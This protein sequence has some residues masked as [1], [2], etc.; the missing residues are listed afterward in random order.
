MNLEVF[1]TIH[2]QELVYHLENHDNGKYNKIFNNIKYTY[3]FV[4]YGNVDMIKSYE[5]V[6]ICRD[7]QYNIEEYKYL[8]DFTSWYA[9]VKNNL[10]ICDNLILIQYDTNLSK[11]FIEETYSKIT[12]NTI[13]SYCNTTIYNENFWYNKGIGIVKEYLSNKNITLEKLI[14]NYILNENDDMW[15]TTNN[16]CCKFDFL[17]SF[18]EDVENIL[19]SNGD[20]IYIGHSFERI[21]YVYCIYNLIDI[22]YITNILEHYQLDSHKS[23]NL[24]VD[25]DTYNLIIN[26]FNNDSL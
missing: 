10:N 5:N 19:I 9:I 22:K 11:N 4:G 21:I 7:L 1:I 3:L 14:F 2:D 17:K 16:I 8:V 24:N 12:D 26:K 13:I 6:I 18:V 25:F 15:I 23:Q 20:N